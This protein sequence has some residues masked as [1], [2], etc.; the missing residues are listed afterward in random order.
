M[1]EDTK[2]AF[3][4]EDVADDANVELFSEYYEGSLASEVSAKFAKRLKED[5]AYAKVYADFEKTMEVL[6][7]MHRMSAPHD[8]DKKVEDTIHKRSGGRFFGRKAFGERIPY[9]ILAVIALVLAGAIYWMGRT[10]DSGGHKI[11][12]DAVPEMHELPQ[13]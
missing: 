11:D 1:E 5:S 3:E 4:A 2:S 10:S 13:K 12:N 9:E 8:F 7:G 6:S